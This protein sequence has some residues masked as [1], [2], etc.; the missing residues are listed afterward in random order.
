M[1]INVRGG[2]LEKYQTEMQ[3]LLNI[4]LKE[5]NE[6]LKLSQER[7][8]IFIEQGDVETL[9][10]EREINNVYKSK[11]EKIESLI[12]LEC[13]AHSN[14]PSVIQLGFV[15]SKGTVRMNKVFKSELI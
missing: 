1:L 8:E 5:V 2:K 6:D 4:I 13:S 3:L 10:I 14:C 12:S 15:D 9:E 11:K 7:V